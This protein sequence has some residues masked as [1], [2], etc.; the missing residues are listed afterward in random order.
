MLSTNELRY[1]SPDPLPDQTPLQA[2]ALSLLF[3]NADLRNIRLGDHE[4]IN[5]IYVA[6]RDGNW[7]T[8]VPKITV[9]RMD[10]TPQSFIIDLDIQ[11]QRDEIDFVWQGRITGSKDSTITF[12]MHGEALS[13]F[14]RNRIGFCVLYPLSVS[15]M[16]CHVTH[17]DGRTSQG[18]FPTLIAPQHQVAGRSAPVYPFVD[19]R[20]MVIPVAG[21]LSAAVQFEGE[22]FEMED[23]RN[24]TDASFKVYGTPQ[25]IPAPVEVEAGTRIEQTITLSLRGSIPTFTVTERAEVIEVTS[26]GSD[27][28]SLLPV[29][30]AVAEQP[31]SAFE[32]Q[33]LEALNLSHLRVDLPLSDDSYPEKLRRA[34]QDAQTLNVPLEI[35]ILFNEEDE[36]R[37]LVKVLEDVKPPIAR[38]LVFNAQGT[39]S[40]PDQL[41]LARYHLSGVPFGGGSTANFTEANRNRPSADLLDFIVFAANP[42]VHAFDNVSIMETAP[43]F[44]M[45]VKT[46]HDFTGLPVAIS[47]ITL[48]RRSR[49]DARQASLFCAAWTVAVFKYV[50]ESGADYTTLFETVGKRGVVDGDSVFPVYYVLAD[51]GAFTGGEVIATRSSAPLRVESLMLRKDRRECLLLAN[52]TNEP[53]KVI[54]NLA[55][56]QATLRM[57]DETSAQ[58]A[59]HTP[60][61]FRAEAP[62]PLDTLE[63]TLLPYAVARINLQQG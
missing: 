55:V 30:L 48:N 27:G 31:I 53:Q 1:G 43:T 51:V 59:M 33:R 18:E 35:A 45:T 40:T 16:N 22:V 38:W 62:T 21:E 10:V 57:L 5:R 3:E 47:P 60:E 63:C 61:A 50:A 37:R 49:D 12:T 23:Q 8:I 7:N 52:M 41:W 4:I 25:R 28:D 19:I 15:G 11:H 29:G 13:T 32:A 24:W 9:T 2:G 39:A 6:V 56:S 46:A 34:V 14:W 42:Q 36:L 20:E 44:A 54:L 26:S 58:G 17:T